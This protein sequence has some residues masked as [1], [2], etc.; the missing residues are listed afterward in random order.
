MVVGCVCAQVFAL[1]LVSRACMSAE[2]P[3]KAIEEELVAIR[4]EHDALRECLQ[5]AARA[6]IGGECGER[7][8][9]GRASR[10]VI[11]EVNIAS[12]ASSCARGHE[13]HVAHQTTILQHNIGRMLM[14]VVG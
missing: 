7:G 2:E 13:P 9:P 4:E 6:K 10:C 11:L 3:L 5:A 14:Q 8:M 12:V 1:S